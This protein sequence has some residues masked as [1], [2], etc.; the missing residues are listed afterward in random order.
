VSLL[1]CLGQLRAILLK[2]QGPNSERGLALGQLKLFQLKSFGPTL[3]VGF[4]G[5]LNQSKAD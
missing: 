4:G 1:K 3:G 5:P 2:V